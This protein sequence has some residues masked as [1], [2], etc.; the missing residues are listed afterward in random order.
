MFYGIY[1]FGLPSA[2]KG[3]LCK[4]G[5]HF[6]KKGSCISITERL[7]CTL[8]YHVW[9]GLKGLFLFRCLDAEVNFTYLC[10]FSGIVMYDYS[11][12]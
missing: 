8:M 4:C 1:D 2:N 10:V 6:L 11:R 7:Y 9:F 12:A 3:G 5:P